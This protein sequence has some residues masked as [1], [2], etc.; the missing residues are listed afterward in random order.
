M[1][2]MKKANFQNEFSDF[3]FVEFGFSTR[4]TINA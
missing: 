3:I 1:I 2:C 4:T